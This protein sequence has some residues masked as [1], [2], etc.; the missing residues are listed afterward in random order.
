MGAL[1]DSTPPPNSGSLEPAGLFACLFSGVRRVL[2]GARWDCA[3]FRGSPQ[4][5]QEYEDP[6]YPDGGPLVG[7]PHACYHHRKWAELDP[8][9]RDIAVTY[10]KDVLT[11]DQAT[12]TRQLMEE[13]PDTW[14]VDHHHFFGM[15][16]RNRLRD[17]I[18]DSELPTGCWDDYYVAAMEEAVGGPEDVDT[19]WEATRYREERASEAR[20]KRFREEFADLLPPVQ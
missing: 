4:P 6:T 15:Y 11:V 20:Q 9:L 13:D 10:L 17:V 16:I 18:K 3:A 2:P 8:E 19:S 1:A 12:E 14:M 5:V 7:E